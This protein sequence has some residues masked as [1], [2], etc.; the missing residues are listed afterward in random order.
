MTSVES[1]ILAIRT[2]SFIVVSNQST[3]N[4]VFLKSF[5]LGGVEFTGLF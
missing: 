5:F 4:D 1:S 2:F 3:N